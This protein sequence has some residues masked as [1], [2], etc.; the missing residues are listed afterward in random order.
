MVDGIARLVAPSSLARK[1]AFYVVLGVCAVVLLQQAVMAARY[2]FVERV[3]PKAITIAAA[4]LEPLAVDASWIIE[5]QPS[6]R[7]LSFGV[8]PD[9][10]T[11]AGMWECD[12]PAK[13]RWHY[14]VD[15]SLY[16]LEGAVVLD[17]DGETH[18]LGP[19]SEAFFPAGSVV[20][21]TVPQH[22]KKA[23]SI[24][25]PGHLRRLI[26]RILGSSPPR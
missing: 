18:S 14:G 6:F 5:G 10:L 11:S 7:A 19:G 16:I 1:R 24:S 13:F 15:E 8:S 20:T 23:F 25:D 3:D 9:H 4:P 22:V 17:F 2:A 26:R 21:W 12:G